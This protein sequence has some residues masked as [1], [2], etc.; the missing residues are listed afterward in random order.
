MGS[1]VGVAM[2]QSKW[3]WYRQGEP[4]RLQ[5]LQLFDDATRGPWGSAQLLFSLR[6]R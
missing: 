4:R 1:A 3:L 2:S 6:A 5:D